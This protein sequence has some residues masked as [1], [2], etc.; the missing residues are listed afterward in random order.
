MDIFYPVTDDLPGVGV[1]VVVN[2][3]GRQFPAARTLDK[4]TRRVRWATEQDGKLVWLPMRDWPDECGD[5]P[6]S[7]RPEKPELWKAPL[8]PPLLSTEP[9]FVDVRGGRLR[10]AESPRTNKYA[11]MAAQADA[12]DRTRAELVAEFGEIDEPSAPDRPEKL[13]WLSERLTYSPKGC[14]SEHE[15]EGRIARAIL[16]DGIRPDDFGGP[17]P[18]RETSSALSQF[19]HETLLSTDA[20]HLVARFE[21]TP[22]DLSDYVTAF[23]WFSELNPPHMRQ[24]GS[25]IWEINHPQKV[26]VW[27]ITGSSWRDLASLAGGSHTGAKKVYGRII[28]EVTAIANGL[29]LPTRRAMSALRERNRKAKVEG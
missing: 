3:V 1:R 17:G 5:E 20:E 28:S 25:R 11:A 19:I 21:P 24:A 22:R 12:S 16:T 13:W 27:R 26:L 2:W 23:G 7:W 9:R 8:P 18:L 6:D 29:A 15:A 14:I 4:K 10:E